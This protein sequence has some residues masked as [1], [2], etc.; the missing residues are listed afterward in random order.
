MR[1]KLAVLDPDAANNIDGPNI[2]RM[3]RALEVIL[4][5][6]KSFSSQKSQSGSPFDI[7]QIGLI[8][9]RE[10]LYQRIDP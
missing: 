5:S 6:G 2:R 4:T 9:A 10:E 1:K 8:R 3:V 7:L